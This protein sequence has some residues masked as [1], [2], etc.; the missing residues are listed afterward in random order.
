MSDVSAQGEDDG[1]YTDGYE[2]YYYYYEDEETHNDGYFSAQ[3]TDLAIHP[4][5]EFISLPL[6]NAPPTVVEMFE[7]ET[8]AALDPHRSTFESAMETPASNQQMQRKYGFKRS[9]GS[10]IKKATA[11]LVNA[12]YME[13]ISAQ[14]GCFLKKNAG[15]QRVLDPSLR[16][17]DTPINKTAEQQSAAR[18]GVNPKEA[19]QLRLKAKAEEEKRMKIR[20]PMGSPCESQVCT[21]CKVIVEEFGVPFTTQ[22]NIP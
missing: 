1:Y 17:K 7:A 19:E 4:K 12:K 2:Y 3:T 13:E 9:S 10:G 5:D 6:E 14:F 15:P 22:R 8:V 18:R 20:Y 21:A 16:L 11:P